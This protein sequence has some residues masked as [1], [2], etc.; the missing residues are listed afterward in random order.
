MDHFRARL[1]KLIRNKL[2]NTALI[3]I[4]FAVATNSYAGLPQH[5][6]VPGG[7]AVIKLNHKVNL[8]ETRAWFK[9]RR[10]MLKSFN[11]ENYAIIGLPLS[12]KK[13]TYKFY[14]KNKTKSFY[15]SF[16][17]NDK[18]YKTQHITV[19]NKRHVNPNA[20]DMKRIRKERK[21]I[22]AALTN[23][24][25]NPN[26]ETLFIKPAEGVYSSPFGLRRYFNGQPRRPHSG[27][28]I[29]APTGTPVIAPAA[30]RI[31]EAGDY[32]FNGKTVFIDH[33]QNL[34]TMYCHLSEISKP[35]GAEVKQGES[36]AKIGATGRVTGAHLHWSVSLNNTRVEPTLFLPAE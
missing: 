9:K 31:I 34:I 20:A 14:V 3:L 30:G 6:A 4:L 13:N 5:N 11:N 7:V 10:V 22:S 24:Q 12:L 36:F 29:A 1:Q 2:L 28:D 17:V 15:Q 23:W 33:G 21:F 18:K 27:L 32:F 25:D 35:V 16:I 8:A 19:K 26:P